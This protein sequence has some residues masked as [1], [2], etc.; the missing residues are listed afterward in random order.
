VYYTFT[1]MTQQPVGTV[2]IGQQGSD[3]IKIET[4]SR[5][6]HEGWF[7]AKITVR[8]SPFSGSYT[9]SFMAGELLRFAEEIEV[10]YRELNSVA[11]LRPIEPHIELRMTGDGRGHIKVKCRAEGKLAYGP[12]LS[13]ELEL[14][15]TQL[16]KIASSL[17]AIEQTARN[18]K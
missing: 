9:A 1:T 6:T 4:S 15:Q 12:K 5:A 7:D 2:L 18:S 13:F 16:P 3:F 8:C 10:L 14:D 17:I 11:E